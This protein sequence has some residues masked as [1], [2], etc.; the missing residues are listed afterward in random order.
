MQ[1]TSDTPLVEH[2]GHFRH[3]T[4]GTCRPLQTR[5]MDMQPRHARSEPVYGQGQLLDLGTFLR[6]TSE[7]G[8]DPQVVMCPQSDK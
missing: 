6:G 4:R 3:A 2:A 1:A 7:E 8:C 5:Q